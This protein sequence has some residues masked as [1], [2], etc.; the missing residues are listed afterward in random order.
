MMLL[1]QSLYQ[2]G[3]VFRSLVDPESPAVAKM[4]RYPLLPL[5]LPSLF[6]YLG[7]GWFGWRLGAE[8]PLFFD[9]IARIPGPGWKQ[10]T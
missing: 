8:K 5:L 4:Q 10:Y 2:L 7:S 6:A 9:H 1:L 3:Q